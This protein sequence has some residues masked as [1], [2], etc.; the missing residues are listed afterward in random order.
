M[1]C[2]RGACVRRVPVYSLLLKWYW[3]S[4]SRDAEWESTT[5]IN[6]KIRLL[7]RILAEI[8]CFFRHR[9]VLC[10]S[11]IASCSQAWPSRH[12]RQHKVPPL[13]KYSTERGA[14]NWGA[15]DDSEDGP[16]MNRCSFFK[17]MFSFF[18]QPSAHWWKEKSSSS[19]FHVCVVCQFSPLTSALRTSL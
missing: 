8:R 5:Y 7:H 17:N 9:Y 12:S 15:Q 18:F 14:E 19:H 4:A 6:P 13:K 3:S 1:I 11:G 10:L 16:F 2:L